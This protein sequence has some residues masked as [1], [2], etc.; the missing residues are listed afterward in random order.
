MTYDKAKLQELLAK[1]E[2]GSEAAVTECC[3]DFNREAHDRGEYFPSHDMMKA[4]RGSLDAALAL[5]KAVLPGWW[6]QVGTCGLSDDARCAPDFNNPT[7]GADLERRFDPAVD[8]AALTDVDQR[9][10]G[11]LARALLI[12]ILKAL[13]AGCDQ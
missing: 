10:S 9:P 6:F 3:R 8:W 5:H 2:S 11:N 4:Y 7:N 1:V 12:A 13:M